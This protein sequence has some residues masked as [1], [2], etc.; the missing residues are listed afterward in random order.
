MN[1][2]FRKE[3]IAAVAAAL[4]LVAA[5]AAPVNAQI[6]PLAAELEISLDDVAWGNNISGDVVVTGKL[7]CSAPV[8]NAYMRI[9]VEQDQG[10]SSTHAYGEDWDVDC[11]DEIMWSLLAHSSSEIDQ[12]LASVNAYVESGGEN[13]EATNTVDVKGCTIIGS[14]D[15]ERIEGSPRKDII[16]GL[17]GNDVIVGKGGNDEIRAYDGRDRIF[18]GTGIDR[19]LAGYGNDEVYGGGGADYLDGD[20]NDDY[21]SGGSGRDECLGGTGRN[22]FNSCE[23]KTKG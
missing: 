4:A 3:L 22:R 8:E 2:R 1:M 10:N 5:L 6:P 18:G 7:T 13:D 17:Q 20:E 23:I 11:T 21:V 14:P 16:C 15:S 9:E 12:G 19:V